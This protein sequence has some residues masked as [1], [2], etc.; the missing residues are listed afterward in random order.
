MANM[1][2]IQLTQGQEVAILTRM[3]DKDI[4]VPRPKISRS[5]VIRSIYRYRFGSNTH[6][7]HAMEMET[8]DVT[9]TSV[10]SVDS[11]RSME[12]SSSSNSPPPPPPPPPPLPPPSAQPASTNAALSVVPTE[13]T[14]AD[15]EAWLSKLQHGT[16]LTETE[17]KT[18]TELARDRLLQESNVQPVSAPV[19]VCGDIH[20]QWHDLM[21][22]FRI[23]GSAPDTNYL[24]MVRARTVQRKLCCLLV[25]IA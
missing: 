22:L 12:S 25:K 10:S 23:G 4:L 6:H 3:K 21:E 8:N 17:V 11:G 20:G 15:L 1:T 19:T 13:S 7:L 14:Y 24:F 18:L 9:S 5:L 16:P 2:D